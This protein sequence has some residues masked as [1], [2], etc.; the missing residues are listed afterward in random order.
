MKKHTS[1][2]I[3]NRRRKALSNLQTQLKAGT[4][5]VG[6]QQFDSLS[7]GDIKR[8]EKEIDI[9]QSKLI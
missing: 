6:I 1:N 2:G 8:I 4:K 7:I 9:L 5:R 3:D